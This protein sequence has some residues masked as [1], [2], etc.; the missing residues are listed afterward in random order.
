[1]GNDSSTRQNDGADK[2][3]CYFIRVT[4]CIEVILALI[5]LCLAGVFF[6][7]HSIDIR[8]LV[9]LALIIT[10]IMVV[11]VYLSWAIF[12]YNI[13][14]GLTDEDWKK[15]EVARFTGKELYEP[16]ENPNCDNSLGLP[17]GTIRGIIALTLLVAMLALAIIYFGNE[18]SVRENEFFVDS[19]D[20]FKTAFLM[21]IAF[22]FGTKSLE[23]LKPSSGT[24]AN[25][26]STAGNTASGKPVKTNSPSTVQDNVPVKT[27]ENAEG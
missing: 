9:A 25:S 24:A 21:M 18:K 7:K 3:K 23:F 2:I 12:F 8:T 4:A 20:F 17:P 22:Y 11:I 26:G 6:I 10:W 1:M 5:L 16:D 14:M 27:N 19:L 13:N 15:I